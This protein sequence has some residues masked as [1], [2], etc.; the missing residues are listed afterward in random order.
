[1]NPSSAGLANVNA[2]HGVRP[3]APMV[4]YLNDRLAGAEGGAE[5]GGHN[6]DVP[7]TRWGVGGG[8]IL[9]KP[10]GV[11]RPAAM[12]V[13]YGYGITPPWPDHTGDHGRVPE[14]QLPP[15]MV[16]GQEPWRAWNPQTLRMAPTV[17]WDSGVYQ[18][19]AS[20][21]GGTA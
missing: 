8:A 11:P 4:P 6:G 14:A 5:P 10:V 7:L 9:D 18:A 12:G 1:M 2:P 21:A 16:G 20:G 3:P 13:T 19:N 17:P 15:N